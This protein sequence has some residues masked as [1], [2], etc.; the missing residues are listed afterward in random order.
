ME[1]YA[2]ES[3]AKTQATKMSAKTGDTFYIEQIGDEFA[4]MTGAEFLLLKMEQEAA[5]K[6]VAAAKDK[7]KTQDDVA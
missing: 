1:T 2:K 7:E 6:V 5:K 4:V 3:T